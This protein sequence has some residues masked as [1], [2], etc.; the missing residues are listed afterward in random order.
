MK[1][2]F[3]VR[4]AEVYL[5]N[6]ATTMIDP[7]VVDAMRPVLEENYG[8]PE[9]LYH[10]GQQ[11]KTAV[12][13]AR[14]QVAE[15]MGVQSDRV[16]FTSGGT[17]AN[18]WAL[19]CCPASR[20]AT[21]AI[22]HA[23]VLRPIES[24]KIGWCQ[25]PV[26]KTGLVDLEFL[27]KELSEN[28]ADLVSIQYAN[29]EI[30]TVQPIRAIAEIVHAANAVFHVDAVQAFGKLIFSAEDDGI[31]M[32]SVSAH[33]IHG[34]M[35]I[36]ALYAR[37]ALALVPLLHGGLQESGMRA[38]TLP[39]HQIVG[40]GAAAE[41]ARCTMKQEIPRQT[42]LLKAFSA[43]IGKSIQYKRNGNSEKC[44][45]NILSCCITGT[46]ALLLAALLNQKFGICVACGAAC[47]RGNP[48]HVLKAIG[49]SDAENNSTLRISISRFST[50]K[51]VNFFAASLQS[52]I[53]MSRE[54]SVV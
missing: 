36:G 26:D 42:E 3:G 46:E 53:R 6:A 1:P 19:K 21:S 14:E 11:A 32:M 8:N 4:N 9:T 38:G 30:G 2:V 28:H 17:E 13:K 22:E 51:Q 31:D 52:A 34:P 41:K 29:N 18:N 23:S 49:L 16:F 33:K 47:S 12:D 15:L 10:L 44:L 54:R 45:P 5:D 40:F 35:G 24:L 43:E 25:V 27:K 20:I 39:V 7:D 50:D 48:S 37:P